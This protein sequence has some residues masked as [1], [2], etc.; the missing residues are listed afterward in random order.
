MRGLVLQLS[1]VV[2]QTFTFTL[3]KAHLVSV[4][5]DNRLIMN[6]EI[7]A[8]DSPQLTQFEVAQY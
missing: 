5:N 3:Q 4:K 6:Q 1:S 8:A 7:A 2:F